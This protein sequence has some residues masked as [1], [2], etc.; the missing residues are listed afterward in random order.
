MPD[1]DL[2]LRALRLLDLTDLNDG[3]R[4]DHV[5]A[6]IQKAL[7]PHGPVAA[8]C[9][10]PQ[11]VSLAKARLKGKPVKVATVIN[12]PKG[13]DDVERAIEDTE[14][15]LDDGAD[16][17][18][19]VMP[20]RAL[21][22]GDEIA[23]RSMIGEVHELVDDARARLKVI[24]ETGELPDQATI[25]KAADIAIDCGAH[26][27]KTS[28]GKTKTSATPEAVRTMLAAIKAAD[29]TVGLKPSGGIRTLADAKLYL[30]LVD[31]DMGPVWVSQGTFRFGASGLY[32]ALMA[33][34]DGRTETTSVKGPY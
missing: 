8:V 2:A 24:L 25:R 6:L 20:Y 3:C 33:V 11:F 23:V 14:E 17:I 9:I 19:L 27:I 28:T 31:A 10:W 32:D 34:I 16:E 13:G 29:R 15:A 30:D 18:D 7:T 5:E 21:L 1:K 12:F 22:A 4:E 26:F